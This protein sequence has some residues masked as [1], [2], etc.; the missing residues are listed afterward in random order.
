LMTPTLGPRVRLGVVTTDLSLVADGRNGDASVLDFC[1]VCQKCAACCP[2]RAIPSGARQEIDGVLRWRIDSDLCF[3]YWNVLGTDCGRCMAVCPYSHPTSPVHNLIRWVVGQSG[4]GRR[5]AVRL[6][7]VMYGS[8]PP[9]KPFPR[10]LPPDWGATSRSRSDRAAA[11][12]FGQEM[13]DHDLP[14]S[15]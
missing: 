5:I 12:N 13:T 2:P 8:R 14:E 9:S 15:R 6:D 10:W 11:E 1:S 7:D 3:R 4:V